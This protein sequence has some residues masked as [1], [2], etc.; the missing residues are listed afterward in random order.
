MKKRTLSFLLALVMCLSLLPMTAL[1]A[2]DTL[3]DV[4]IPKPAAP[5]YFMT[6]MEYENHSG[7]IRIVTLFDNSMLELVRENDIDPEGFYAKYGITNEY[8][9]GLSIR[10]QYDV[11]VDGRGWQ[12]TSE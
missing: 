2:G 8:Y 6:D 4:P 12:Y 1:A 5:N 3:K 10:M 9:N 11:N 7:D